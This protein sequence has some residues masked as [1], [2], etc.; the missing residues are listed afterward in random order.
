MCYLNSLKVPCHILFIAKVLSIYINELHYKFDLRMSCEIVLNVW[1]TF[2]LHLLNSR[3]KGKISWPQPWAHDHMLE[4]L[5][6]CGIRQLSYHQG[7][8]LPD[9]NMKVKLVFYLPTLMMQ[10]PSYNNYNHATT[11]VMH[12][13]SLANSKEDLQ[14]PTNL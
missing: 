4:R 10:L 6:N 3:F 14:L 5:L 12:I 8:R 11:I 1:S 13:L 2:F 7:K 9:K